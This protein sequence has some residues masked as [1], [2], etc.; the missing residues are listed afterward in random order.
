MAPVAQAFSLWGKVTF[1]PCIQNNRLQRGE[2]IASGTSWQAKRALRSG[3]EDRQRIGERINEYGRR[4]AD[5]GRRTAKMDDGRWTV[6]W[7]VN[8][9]PW[10]VVVRLSGLLG[11]GRQRRERAFVY[12]LKIR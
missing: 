12:S 9:R 10:T 5:R 4:T 8:S 6:E 2:R 1:P 7:T 3:K 11:E